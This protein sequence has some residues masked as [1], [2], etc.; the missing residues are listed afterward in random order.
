M[1]EVP[2]IAGHLGMLTVYDDLPRLDR[3]TYGIDEGNFEKKCRDIMVTI[4][5][6]SMHSQTEIH[7]GWGLHN[8]H[9]WLYQ[10]R[11]SVSASGSGRSSSF[12]RVVPIGTRM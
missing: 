1:H 6:A 7:F 12:T 8:Q 11:G 9:K 5:S 2:C 10:R 4:R 3:Q